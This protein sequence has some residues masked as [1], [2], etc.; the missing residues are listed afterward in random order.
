MTASRAKLR[1]Y[2]AE[3]LRASGVVVVSRPHPRELEVLR[4]AAGGA[5]LT[6]VARITGLPR[7]RVA[8]LL[9]E[10]YAKLGVK[11]IPCHH[12]SQDRRQAA[13][14]VARDRGWL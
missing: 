1:R 4:A 7:T 5:P 11:D 12:L 6:E 13:V 2:A 10:C 14:Q 8:T 3:R 9:S